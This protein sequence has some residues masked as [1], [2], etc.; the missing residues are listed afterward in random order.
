MQ[1]HI[2]AGIHDNPV[3]R[4]RLGIWLEALKHREDS[5]KFIAVEANSI[6][7]LSVIKRQRDEFIKLSRQDEQLGK[8]E[9]LLLKKLS[10]SIAYEADTHTDVFGC[11]T[12]TIWLDDVRPDIDL[13]IDPCSTARRYLKLCHS[14]LT[15]AELTLDR[16]L[17]AHKLFEAIDYHLVKEAEKDDRADS[18][19][20]TTN[21]DRDKAW[22]ELLRASLIRCEDSDYGIIIVGANHAQNEPEYLRYLLVKNGHECKVHFLSEEPQQP[23]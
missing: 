10:L 16:F 19:K 7:F 22:M 4:R 5:P 14:A 1:L 11:Q 17:R 9:R 13:V 18:L 8:I 15:N 12:Q 20:P 3:H 23:H 6:L 2:S 21:F